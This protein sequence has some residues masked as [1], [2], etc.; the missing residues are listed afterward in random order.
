MPRVQLRQ[1]NFEA[2]VFMTGVG[3]T[4]FGSLPAAVYFGIDTYYPG[5]FSAAMEHAAPLYNQMNQSSAAPPQVLW[6]M[7]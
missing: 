7:P 5:G 3:F 4:G 6:G 1:V 2:D